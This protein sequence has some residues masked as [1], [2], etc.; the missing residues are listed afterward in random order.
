MFLF[1]LLRS[2]LVSQCIL[3]LCPGPHLSVIFLIGSDPCLPCLPWAPGRGSFLHFCLCARPEAGI[4]ILYLEIIKQ[5]FWE[6]E[7]KGLCLSLS[8]SMPGLFPRMCAAFLCS[9]TSYMLLPAWDFLSPTTR[10]ILLGD[11]RSRTDSSISISSGSCPDLAQL[12]PAVSPS[13]L[14]FL[15]GLN[16]VESPFPCPWFL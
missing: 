1:N 11:Q 2:A 4:V 3:S 8:N 9:V 10:L 13:F 5:R 16:R 6:T 14:A 7:E 12:S 15:L